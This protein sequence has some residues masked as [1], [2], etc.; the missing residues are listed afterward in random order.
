MKK[1]KRSA[2]SF[3]CLPFWVG[4]SGIGAWGVE[5]HNTP[6]NLRDTFKGLGFMVYG[7]RFMV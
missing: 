1:K 6:S 2:F 7:F 3:W 5:L 4:G